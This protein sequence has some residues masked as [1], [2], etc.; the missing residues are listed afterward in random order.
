MASRRRTPQPLADP[1]AH[2]PPTAS[3]ATSSDWYKVAVSASD[4]STVVTAAPSARPS[5]AQHDAGGQ[6]QPRPVVVGREVDG[7]AAA[8]PPWVISMPVAAWTT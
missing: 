5:S 6:Q 8:P 1:V 7:H 3:A 4:A 2:L